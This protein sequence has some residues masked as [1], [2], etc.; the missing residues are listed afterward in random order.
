MVDDIIPVPL[1]IVA[2]QMF[3]RLKRSSEIEIGEKV[4][5]QNKKS[6]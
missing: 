4:G 5:I 6:Y 2:I 3:A 1:D